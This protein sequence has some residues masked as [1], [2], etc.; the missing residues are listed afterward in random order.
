MPCL[1]PPTPFFTPPM[2]TSASAHL[3]QSSTCITAHLRPPLARPSMISGLQSLRAWKRLDV[4]MC[5][6]RSDAV[7]MIF[8]QITAMCR[9]TAHP[10]SPSSSSYIT[11][12]VGACV[13]RTRC[14][15]C[16]SLRHLDS[17]QARH[18]PCHALHSLPPSTSSVPH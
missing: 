10:P 7:H 6:T 2:R 9:S 11:R 14:H 4:I 8:K 3:T 5:V 1:L 13:K 17:L 12:T 16:H 18:Y 15:V